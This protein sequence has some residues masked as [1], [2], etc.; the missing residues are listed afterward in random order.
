MI[1]NTY[2]ERAITQTR[3]AQWIE[4]L[5]ECNVDVLN[6]ADA[7][8]PMYIACMNEQ[9][10]PEQMWWEDVGESELGNLDMSELFHDKPS[11]GGNVR[12]VEETDDE[13]GSSIEG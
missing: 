13:F 3:L 8:T 12:E 4:L 6:L 7:I 5:A 2:I 11:Q 1:S 9:A 10:P